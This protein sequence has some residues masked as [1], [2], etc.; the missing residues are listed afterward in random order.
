MLGQGGCWGEDGDG[1]K[2]SCTKYDSTEP[3]PL[4]LN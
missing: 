4:G 1:R 3:D 2:K